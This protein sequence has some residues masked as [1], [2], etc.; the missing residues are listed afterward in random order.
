M[1]KPEEK[2]SIERR[3]VNG[4]MMIIIIITIITDQG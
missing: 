3:C 2:S 1:G 4:M